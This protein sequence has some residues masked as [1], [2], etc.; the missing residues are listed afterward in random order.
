MS[1]PRE[2]KCI[3]CAGDD[4]AVTTIEV[5]VGTELPSGEP[6]L[7][8]VA[9]H[10]RHAAEA[11][12]YLFAY[13]RH[14]MRDILIVVF[15]PVLMVATVPL[16]EAVSRLWG[17]AHAWRLGLLSAMLLLHG[18]YVIRFPYSLTPRRPSMKI[19]GLRRGRRVVQLAGGTVA[20]VGAAL[21]I[22]AL[23]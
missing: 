11:R 14:A 17:S 23:A 6:R 15:G 1:V 2:E 9:V 7:E 4:G 16:G 8:E 19:G 10:P 20:L 13:A 18:A 12:D 22:L 3:W 21:G 5:P